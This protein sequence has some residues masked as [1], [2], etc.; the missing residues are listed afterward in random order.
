MRRCGLALVLA[1]GLAAALAGCGAATVRRTADQK[2][3]APANVAQLRWRTLIHQHAMA[4]ARPEEC[5]TG[6]LVGSKL[7]I[8]SR[9]GRVVALDTNDGR[10]LWSTALS[11]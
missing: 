1:S 4:D 11:G 2:G 6:A 5:A 10:L 7:I 8:G 9:G 3:E